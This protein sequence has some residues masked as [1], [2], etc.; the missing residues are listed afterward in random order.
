MLVTNEKE[1]FARKTMKKIVA[2]AIVA[3]ILAV[4]ISGAAKD[5]EIFKV[6][7]R[8]LNQAIIDKN[9]A[10]GYYYFTLLEG[11]YNY[12]R[13]PSPTAVFALR[14]KLKTFHI[15]IK[16]LAQE[17]ASVFK[18]PEDIKPL[19]ERLNQQIE[20]MRKPL[21]DSEAKTKYLILNVASVDLL[22]DVIDARIDALEE[23]EAKKY[24]SYLSFLINLQ[25]FVDQKDFIIAEKGFWE[26]FKKDSVK[27]ITTIY[28]SFVASIKE[29]K[30]A[31]NNQQK[32]ASSLIMAEKYR[33]TLE[34]YF[35]QIQSQEDK[36][37]ILE[38][39]LETLFFDF[40]LEKLAQLYNKNIAP[41]RLVLLRNATP[42]DE[43]DFSFIQLNGM[44]DSIVIKKGDK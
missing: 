16:Q 21:D 44:P 39:L 30:N 14:Q 41:L 18:F 6:W 11:Y 43:D 35:Y 19:V 34:Y 25:S 13:S 29:A 42:A 31:T 10:S 1:I 15:P 4:N 3:C 37:A 27:N 22:R 7:H 33:R 8:E 9:K 38:A 36:K 20:F 40:N 17:T 23:K 24:K 28:N 32:K 12:E 5:P 2:V 26:V